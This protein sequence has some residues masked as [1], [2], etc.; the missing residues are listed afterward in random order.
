MPLTNTAL[1][2]AKLK[3][4]PY[5]LA[6]ERGLYLLVNAAGKYFRFDYRFAGKRKTLALGVYPDVSLAD[7]RDRRDRARKL[8]SDAIDP[9][10]QRKV[11]RATQAHRT[12]NSFA[13]VARE[14][15]AKFSPNWAASHAHK[16]IRRLERDVF[17]WIGAR[18]VAEVTAPEL[19]T[20]L[21][22]GDRA[23]AARPIG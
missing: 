8:L 18:P 11:M 16:I 4:K 6:D 17:P 5:K 3:Q 15:F 21:R 7:A 20:V 14:W 9:G 23:G 12:A 19:L 10:A 22:R 1:R 13:V 2:N